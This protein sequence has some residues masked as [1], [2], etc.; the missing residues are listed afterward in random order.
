MIFITTIIIVGILKYFGIIDN[1]LTAGIVALVIAGVAA[2]A[3]KGK[4]K[5]PFT[6]ICP[7]SIC[8]LHK[9]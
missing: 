5:C 3:L 1:T 8:P 7:F 4:L 6:R 9:K 2:F